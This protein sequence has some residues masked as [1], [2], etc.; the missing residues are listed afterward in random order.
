MIKAIDDKVVVEELKR[1]KSEGG[2]IF[3]DNAGDPQ[4]YGKVLSIGD[5]VV[6]KQLQVDD[7]IIFHVRGGQAALI[8]RKLLRVLKYDEIY[9]ILED[10]DLLGTLA[11]I[12]IKSVSKEGTSQIEVASPMILPVS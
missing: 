3:P 10:K 12:E 2:I 9:G 7:Y 5:E 11:E 1:T 4:A 8:G 6:N